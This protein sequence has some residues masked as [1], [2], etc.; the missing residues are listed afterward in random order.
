MGFSHDIYCYNIYH[1][2]YATFYTF[3]FYS[4]PDGIIT[5]SIILY[6]YLFKIHRKKEFKIIQ[7]TKQE[8]FEL[9]KLGH[10]F[11]FEGTLHHTWSRKR[12]KYYLTESPKAM[13]DLN[14]IRKSHLENP[15]L[16]IPV[17]KGLLDKKVGG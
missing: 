4:N 2:Y 5:Y 13:A 6:C 10:K 17:F 1:T 15:I 9:E 16:D 14:R 8:R 12:K 7:I 3:L 11:G